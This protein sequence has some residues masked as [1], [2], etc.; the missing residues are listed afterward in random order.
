MGLTT[1]LDNTDVVVVNNDGVVG[2]WS[3]VDFMAVVVVVAV[4]AVVAVVAVSGMAVG[5]VVSA[6]PDDGVGTFELAVERW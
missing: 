6:V 4:L 3:R 2:F 5:D 1:G